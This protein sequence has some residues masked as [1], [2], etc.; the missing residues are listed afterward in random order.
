MR[1]NAVETAAVVNNT[2]LRTPYSHIVDYH[3]ISHSVFILFHFPF[4]LPPQR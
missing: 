1:M 3:H 2:N 4:V